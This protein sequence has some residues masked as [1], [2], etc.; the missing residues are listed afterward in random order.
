VKKNLGVDARPLT[1]REETL[2]GTVTKSEGRARACCEQLLSAVRIPGFVY[3]NSWLVKEMSRRGFARSETEEALKQL[4]E[5]GVMESDG[6]EIRL[7]R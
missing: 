4:T 3:M 6:N 7:R 2:M 5:R 1:V